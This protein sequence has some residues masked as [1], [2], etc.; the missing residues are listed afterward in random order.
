[1]GAQEEGEEL[2]D[3]PEAEKKASSTFS[4]VLNILA[5]PIALKQC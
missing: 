4:A 3:L 5:K 2:Q 1:L